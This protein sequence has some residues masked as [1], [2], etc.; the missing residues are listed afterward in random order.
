VAFS[1]F[2]PTPFLRK[3]D[4]Y[5][6]VIP[7]LFLVFTVTMNHDSTLH[8]FDTLRYGRLTFHFN[9]PLSSLISLLLPKL[10]SVLYTIKNKYL[11]NKFNYEPTYKHRMASDE[12]EGKAVPLEA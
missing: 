3:C 2:I 11:Q 10:N 8:A 12:V 9:I 6:S 5:V 7:F 1:E 4:F